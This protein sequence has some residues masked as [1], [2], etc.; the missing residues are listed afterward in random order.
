MIMLDPHRTFVAGTHP[1]E[2]RDEPRA[3][4]RLAPV[5]AAASEARLL[6]ALRARVRRVEIERAPDTLRDRV[7]AMLD[8][9]A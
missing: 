6:R 4:P 3:E 7:R 8:H 9:R 5:H 1:R 2:P